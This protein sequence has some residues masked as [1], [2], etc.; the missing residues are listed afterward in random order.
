[1]KATSNMSSLNS[2]GIM[3]CLTEEGAAL[4]RG[5]CDEGPASRIRVPL[6]MTIPFMEATLKE[7]AR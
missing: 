2:V 3:E 6:R 5:R 7:N 1:M 4:E